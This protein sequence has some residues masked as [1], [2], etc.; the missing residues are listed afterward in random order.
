ML[1]NGASNTIIASGSD[2]FAL[3][4]VLKDLG[5]SWFS[6]KKHWVRS[7]PSEPAELAALVKELS[8]RATISYPPGSH[9]LAP[10]T[11]IEPPHVPPALN[12]DPGLDSV[13]P[14]LTGSVDF[15][16]SGP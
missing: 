12:L 8:A 9:H 7:A 10:T 5:F 11:E 3:R 15:W 1:T 16:T 4:P 13:C 14:D 6:R 2:T